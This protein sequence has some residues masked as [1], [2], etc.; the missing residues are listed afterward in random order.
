[1]R[2]SLVIAIAALL[3]LEPVVATAQ[4]RGQ[5]GR[6]GQG[7][8]R[9]VRAAPREER[10]RVERRDDRQEERRY[11]PR[12][13]QRPPGPRLDRGFGPGQIL[14][15]GVRGGQLQ[16]FSR[17]RL[18]PPPPGYDWVRVGPDIYLMQRSTGLVLEMIPGGY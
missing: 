10:G 11:D 4:G 2:N 12:G 18:R 7:R 17:H 6:G 1:M 8:G 9:D 16:D 15:P 5:E 14:P 13:P 3:A